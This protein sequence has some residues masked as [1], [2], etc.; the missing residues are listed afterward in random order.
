M[1]RT[2][3]PRVD[4]PAYSTLHK[5]LTT[6]LGHPSTHDCFF[7]PHPAQEWAFFPELC[8]DPIL[9][10][11]ND[12]HDGLTFSHNYE[13]Y[14][15]VCIEHHRMMDGVADKRD[16]LGL[17]G[18]WNETAVTEIPGTI[19]AAWNH[20]EFVTATGISPSQELSYG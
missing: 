17:A 11:G 5:R 1:R 20:G 19:I 6:D 10:E 15:P 18:T 7:G 2:G 14:A 13:D 8:G 9:S 4:K 3:R 16:P 12:K